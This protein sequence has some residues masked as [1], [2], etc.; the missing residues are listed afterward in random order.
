MSNQNAVRRPDI[1]FKR[2]IGVGSY[3]SYG[4]IYWKPLII[5]LFGKVWI[6]AKHLKQN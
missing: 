3:R 4:H 5:Y 1:E 2:K 6:G